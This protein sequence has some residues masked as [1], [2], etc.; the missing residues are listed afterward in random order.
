MTYYA[1]TELNAMADAMAARCAY[2]SIHT[3]DPAPTGSDEAVGGGYARKALTFTPAGDEGVLGP[4]W[5]PAT[6]GVAWSD[7]VDFDVDSG[8]YT[9]LGAWS[10]ATGGIFRCS[11]ILDPEEIVT[12]PG[13][14]S[15]FIG[16]GPI[17]AGDGA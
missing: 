1:D 2:L 5:Q 14:V 4:V 6:V 7:A 12:S 9:H 16:V 13:T 8:V 11:N 15:A 10:A 17:A 3:A